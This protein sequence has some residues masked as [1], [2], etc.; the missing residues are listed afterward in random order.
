MDGIVFF[1]CIC[2]VFNQMA[3]F[4]R[5]LKIC[6]NFMSVKHVKSVSA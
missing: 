3:S 4:K 2:T 5:G 1:L 6:L